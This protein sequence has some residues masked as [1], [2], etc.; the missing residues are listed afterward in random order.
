[1]SP[2]DPIETRGSRPEEEEEA[3]RFL[4]ELATGGSDAVDWLRRRTRERAAPRFS[5]W[6]WSWIHE[7]F[8]SDL[9]LQL[10]GTVA[11]PEFALRGSA[12]AYVDIS[13]ANLCKAYFRQLARHRRGESLDDHRDL[14]ERSAGAARRVAAAA[15]LWRLL[16]GKYVEGLSLKEL[17][18]ATG[19][20]PRT[21]Q[22]RLHTC[23]KRLREVSEKRSSAD[24]QVRPGPL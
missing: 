10:T 11:R 1:M 7:D 15:E 4:R 5:S 6:A 19:T 18:V 2:Q 16:L 9:L 22:S 14:P 3:L 13:I 21:I 24:Q 20:E 8:V 23:R 12:S 17:A